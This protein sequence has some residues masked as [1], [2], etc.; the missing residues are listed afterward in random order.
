MMVTVALGY[1][2]LW[3]DRYCINQSDPTEVLEQMSIMDVIYKNSILTI[4]AA[5]GINPQHG[6]PG[7]SK[8]RRALHECESSGIYVREVVSS[9][10][11]L[12]SRWNQRAWTYQEAVFAR[13][14]LIFTDCEAYYECSSRG[15]KWE[16]QPVCFHFTYS[17]FFRGFRSCAFHDTQHTLDLHMAIVPARIPLTTQNIKN[18]FDL[19]SSHIFWCAIPVAKR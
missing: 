3:V 7:V 9:S 16:S 15:G 13:R 17:S 10:T 6:L 5:C 19:P 12:E 2:Y 18:G 4:I 11:I 14:R 1:R 8:P